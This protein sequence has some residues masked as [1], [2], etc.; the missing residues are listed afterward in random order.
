MPAGLF[1]SAVALPVLA[2]RARRPWPSLGRRLSVVRGASSPLAA[3]AHRRRLANGASSATSLLM[4]RTSDG[5]YAF[6]QN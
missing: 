1:P 4:P 2:S 3:A 6:V 5:D